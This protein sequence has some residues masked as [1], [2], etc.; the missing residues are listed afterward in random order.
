MAPKQKTKKK[1]FNDNK[2][3]VFFC[4]RWKPEKMCYLKCIHWRKKE[5]WDAVTQAVSV[6]SPESRTVAEVKK[7]K[8]K[9]FDMK[10][11]AKRRISVQQ[12]KKDT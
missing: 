5:A 2:R 6:V 4:R 10:F 3:E 9:W 12:R 11:E 7:K 1:N 8:K